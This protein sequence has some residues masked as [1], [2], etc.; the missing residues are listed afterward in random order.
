MQLNI[1][2]ED[3]DILVCEKPAGTPTQTR[4]FGIHDMVSL[5]RSYL[6]ETNPSTNGIPYLGIIHRLDQPVGGIMVFA[7]TEKA[8]SSLSRQ[9]AEKQMKKQ[10]LAILT[11][12]LSNELGREPILLSD[13]MVTDKKQN[14][15]RIVTQK[16]PQAKKAELT[17]QVLSVK[18]YHDQML[19]LIKVNLL[20]GRQH[21]IRL[22]TSYHLGGIFGD[23]KYNPLFQADKSRTYLGLYACHL[24]FLHPATGKKMDFEHVPSSELFQL[25]SIE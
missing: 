19:S 22:Q 7:K 12:D 8:A 9:I 17:Y 5:L 23:K 21:Q 1:L 20:T 24:S 10:Y 4:N 16:T 3:S 13:Y 14:I 6:A 25:F 2:F 11:K 18:S 15:S